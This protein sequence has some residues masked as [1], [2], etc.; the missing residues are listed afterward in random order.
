MKQNR[1]IL[2]VGIVMSFIVMSRGTAEA[3]HTS[4]YDPLE[5]KC[6]RAISKGL[7]KAVAAGQ[8]V[9]SVCHKTRDKSGGSTDCNALTNT[10]ADAKGKFA[11]AQSK[12]STAVAGSCQEGQIGL[13]VLHEYVSCPEPCGTELSLPNPLTSY[14]QLGTCLQCV[15]REEAEANGA[16]VFGLPAAPLAAT[17]RSC[18]TAIGKLYGKYLKTMLKLRTKCEDSAEK[19]GATHMEDTGCAATDP[20]G[21]IT[22]ILTAAEQQV[23]LSCGGANLP[24]L[25]SCA[26]SDLG[27]LKTCLETEHNQTGAASLQ[28]SYG[29]PA[30]ICPIGITTH[31][32]AGAPYVLN[33]DPIGPTRLDSGWNGIGHGQDIVHDYATSVA[34]TCPNSSPPCGACTIDGLD[35]AGEQTSAFTRCKEDSSIP[36]SNAFGT[37]PVCPGLQECGYYLGPPAPLSASNTPTCGLFHLENDIT[38]SVDPDAGEVEQN[39]SLRAVIYTGNALDKPCPVCVGDPTPQDGQSDG[40]CEG[41]ARNGQSCDVQGFDA[42]FANNGGVSL[43]CPPLSG[44]KVTGNGLAL[45]LDLTTGSASLPFNVPCDYLSY[46]TFKCACAVCSN[47][48]ARACDSNAECTAPGTCTSPGAG[49]PRQ[50]NACSDLTCTDVG[51]GVGQ[52]A[53][54]PA[55]KYCDGIVRANG[56]G[57][58]T[59]EDDTTCQNSAIGT[60]GQAGDCILVEPR[61]CFLDP[62]AAAGT[63]DPDRAIM[64]AAFCVPPTGSTSVDAGTGLPGPSRIAVELGID[65]TY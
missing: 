32:I 23:D 53:N 8:K 57:Y 65:R 43:D 48:P 30:T 9:I 42:T 29:L 41:G 63:P 27:A 37:D 52:C 7:T 58:L 2:A 54:G 60:P 35:P 20:G 13:T 47:D 55:V 50:P 61:S 19:S 22:A 36:C 14:A 3:F 10:Q 18:R 59:C 6:R 28:Y 45:N 21:K 24:L 64:V 34:V 5:L 62:I 17:E 49:Q 4:S 44:Q 25:D 56:R 40:T 38:G 1:V 15:A 26:T 12:L 39:I 11:A 31:T 16:A 51:D 46:P 33:E